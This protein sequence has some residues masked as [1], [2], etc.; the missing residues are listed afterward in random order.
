MAPVAVQLLCRPGCQ[1]DLKEMH[2]IQGGVDPVF[3]SVGKVQRF[4]PALLL[5]ARAGSRL[6]STRTAGQVALAGWR[7]V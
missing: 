2:A 3:A 6:V 1:R 7:V 4:R 5:G